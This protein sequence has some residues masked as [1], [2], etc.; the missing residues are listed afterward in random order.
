MDG[1]NLCRILDRD[2]VIVAARVGSELA[3]EGGEAMGTEL[4]TQRVNSQ[5]AKEPIGHPMAWSESRLRGPTLWTTV[6]AH[7]IGWLP[8]SVDP[9]ANSTNSRNEPATPLSRGQATV[10]QLGT[11]LKSPPPWVMT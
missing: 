1:T 6:A 11:N 8:W 2:P 4:T 7:G 10:H 3:E 5:G 9:G